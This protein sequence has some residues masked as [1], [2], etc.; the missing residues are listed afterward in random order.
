LNTEVPDWNFD[1]IKQD[2]HNQW[3][4]QLSKTE[5][6]G[7]TVDQKNIFYTGLYHTA[8]SPY[9]FSD[10]DRRY[11][12]LDGQIHTA[13]KKMF[14]V[15]SLWDTFRAFHPLQN[16]TEPAKNS[17]FV[18]TLITQYQQGGILPMWELNANYTGT[19]VGYHAVPVIVDAYMKGNNDFDA[20]VAYQ[21]IV[22]SAKYDTVG[23]H[24]PS[25]EVKNKLSSITKKYNEERGFIPAD[26]ENESVAKALEYAYDDWCIAQMAE[27]LGKEADYKYFMERSKRYQQYFDKETG[28]MRG[29]N[30]DKSFRVPFDPKYS[31]HRTDDYVEGNAWQWT[32]FVPHDVPGLVNLMGGKD[33]FTAKLDELFSTSSELSGDETSADITGLIGQ[34]AHGNEPSHHITHL[35]NFV[36]QPWKTQKL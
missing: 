14:S 28:F 22:R 3:V 7:G 10:A 21:A 24:Y 26:L 5:V 35:Y 6:E 18:S 15:F 17:E 32:W 4:D 13:E 31:Q 25:E 12:G 33:K 11:K 20:E 29:V 16:I 30:Q 36:E 1:E 2:A 27:K 23:V 34:Y 19:M 9:T 8:M